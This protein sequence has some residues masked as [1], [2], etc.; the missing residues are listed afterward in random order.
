MP[1][2]LLSAHLREMPKLRAE[3]AL[4]GVSVAL[5]GSGRMK[6]H[7]ARGQMRAWERQATDRAD[8]VRLKAK[9]PAEYRLH[10][11]AMGLGVKFEKPE[12]ATDG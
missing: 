8:R 6:R 4:R 2:P 10:M 3:E 1:L 9:T 7:A 11:A 12:P 5:V